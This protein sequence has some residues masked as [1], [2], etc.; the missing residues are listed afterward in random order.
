MG[1]GK[2]L[3]S[4]EA[5]ARMLHLPP[6]VQIV[7]ARL[8]DYTDEALLEDDRVLF[9]ISGENLSSGFLRAIPSKKEGVVRM[10]WVQDS[11]NGE[12]PIAEIT[13]PDRHFS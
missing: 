7:D 9:I 12:K 10:Q 1:T 8:Q 13:F 5:L 3:I 11:P 2:L 6:N 4:I